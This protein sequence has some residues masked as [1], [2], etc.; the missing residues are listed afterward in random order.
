MNLASAS[1]WREA[2][3]GSNYRW[4]YDQY[5]MSRSVSNSQ[6]FRGASCSIRKCKCARLSHHHWHLIDVKK[7]IPL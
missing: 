5:W 4:K 1:G 7:C 6:I 3:S 2:S